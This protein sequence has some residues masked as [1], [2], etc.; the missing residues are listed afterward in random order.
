MDKHT[1]LETARDIRLFYELEDA[2]ERIECAHDI[3][4]RVLEDIEFDAEFGGWYT[5]LSN[6]MGWND[7]TEE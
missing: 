7:V 6:A 2:D 4:N 5:E 1:A 3:I